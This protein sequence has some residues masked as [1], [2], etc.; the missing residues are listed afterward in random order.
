MNAFDVLLA[1][2]GPPEKK[3]KPKP[4]PPQQPQQLQSRKHVIERH[5]RPT[6]WCAPPPPLD[7]ASQRTLTFLS[8]RNTTR[9]AIIDDDVLGV[10]VARLLLLGAT[11]GGVDAALSFGQTCADVRRVLARVLCD[12]TSGLIVAADRL[13]LSIGEFM[14][15]AVHACAAVIPRSIEARGDDGLFHVDGD[16]TRAAQR[17][18]SAK[19]ARDA[20]A[21]RRGRC[22]GALRRAAATVPAA[23]QQ[24]AEQQPEE[25]GP[26]A[27]V[28][29][30]A[31]EYQRVLVG[32]G[33]ADERRRD[34]LVFN[35]DRTGWW[36]DRRAFLRALVDACDVC[37]KP[38][39][40]ATPLRGSVPKVSD[41]EV[42]L[43]LLAPYTCQACSANATCKLAFRSTKRAVAHTT[44]KIGFELICSRFFVSVRNRPLVDALL[45][46]ATQAD[47]PSISRPLLVAELGKSPYT[48]LLGSATALHSMLSTF[49]RVPTTA[50]LDCRLE[51]HIRPPSGSP[52]ERT[53]AAVLL[54]QKQDAFQDGIDGALA[55]TEGVDARRL[56]QQAHA[57]ALRTY[58]AEVARDNPTTV[59][60]TD[61]NACGYR[62]RVRGKHWPHPG[63]ALSVLTEGLPLA[64]RA[65]SYLGGELHGRYDADGA[66]HDANPDDLSSERRVLQ[67]RAR[68]FQ[69]QTCPFVNT[70]VF[71][72]GRR[73]V[74]PVPR[75]HEHRIAH[76]FE[77]LIHLISTGQV[78][79]DFEDCV[80]RRFN[81]GGEPHTR[82]R[83]CVKG[84]RSSAARHVDGLLALV[85]DTTLPPYDH[86]ARLPEDEMVSSVR[87]RLDYVNAWLHRP[88]TG[89]PSTE[90][91]IEHC[92]CMF[93]R[94]VDQLICESWHVPVP[95]WWAQ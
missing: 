18:R 60:A 27:L 12:V 17:I 77:R 57:R 74:R 24:P 61:T 19:L 38:K 40:A 69:K 84:Y 95:P 53:L 11:E 55:K 28:E 25:T 51:F 62:I 72:L 52:V 76:V 4:Q 39:S 46:L 37:G 49:G 67:R 68:I 42:S 21:L 90:R 45:R 7:A 87:R 5:F 43:A 44:A 3:K 10:V 14:Q 91:W 80:V 75:G 8:N 48:A 85:R 35:V 63:Q 22:D 93:D 56:K 83:L 58:A 13:R 71:R 59:A 86:D 2:R 70:L 26:L 82:A 89:H 9:I 15:P 73:V 78:R 65:A 92:G 29:R 20:F 66:V 34:W 81:R 16:G 36:H 33:V 79:F 30:A 23:E 41:K 64:A 54:A 31:H 94:L 88:R 6:A 32:A 1:A 50:H 47:P